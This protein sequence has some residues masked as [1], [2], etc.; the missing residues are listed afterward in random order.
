M[1]ERRILVDLQV[2]SRH[3][4]AGWFERDGARYGLVHSQVRLSYVASSGRSTFAGRARG[5]AWVAVEE[6]TG[7][8][9]WT[10]GQL[11]LVQA[12]KDDSKPDRTE[13]DYTM[14]PLPGDL[15]PASLPPWVPED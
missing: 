15:V 5:S 13:V 3:D 6:D 2:D 10:A 7:L 1:E 11:R 14:G 9:A 12:D 4:F 8:L